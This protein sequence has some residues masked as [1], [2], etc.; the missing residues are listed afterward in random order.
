MKRVVVRYKVKADRLAEHEDLIRKVFAELATARPGGL[1]YHALKLE[2]GVSFVHVATVSTAD[3]ENP[4]TALPAFKAFAA[5][6]A[7][8]CEERAVNSPATALGAYRADDAPA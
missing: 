6:I 2:D 8:R 1:A 4:L 7:D 3:G 5:G